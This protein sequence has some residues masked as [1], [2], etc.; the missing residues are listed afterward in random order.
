MI[1][2]EG[3][4]DHNNEEEAT[5][6]ATKMKDACIQSLLVSKYSIHRTDVLNKVELHTINNSRKM[7]MSPKRILAMN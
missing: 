4:V 7:V 3:E 1:L 5:E 6:G 2:S